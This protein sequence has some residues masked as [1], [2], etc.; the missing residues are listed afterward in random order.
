MLLAVLPAMAWPLA[1]LFSWGSFPAAQATI[2]FL[3]QMLQIFL[4]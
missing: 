2:K 1:L 4:L 3:V